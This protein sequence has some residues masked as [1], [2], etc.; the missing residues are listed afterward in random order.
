MARQLIGNI[1]ALVAIF[2]IFLIAVIVLYFYFGQK[3]IVV[4]PR[5]QQRLPAQET[6]VEIPPIPPTEQTDQN[7]AIDGGE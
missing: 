7:I 5:T 4:D 6:R 2:A 3:R 1:T